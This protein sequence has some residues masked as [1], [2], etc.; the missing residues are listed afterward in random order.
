MVSLYSCFTLLK[1]IH[2]CSHIRYLKQV[3]NQSQS[4]PF[5]R[6]CFRPFPFSL[7][8][9]MLHHYPVHQKVNI[10]IIKGATMRGLWIKSAE[11]KFIDSYH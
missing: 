6:Q 7:S 3:N 4:S 1:A 9:I 8:L 11:Q 5:V 2:S 10:D